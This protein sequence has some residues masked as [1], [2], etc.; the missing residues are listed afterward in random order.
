MNTKRHLIRK[1]KISQKIM[2]EKVGNLLRCGDNGKKNAGCTSVNAVPVIEAKRRD[3]ETN[4]KHNMKT[5]DSAKLQRT[6]K[7]IHF[8]GLREMPSTQTNA[9]EVPNLSCLRIRNK[10]KRPFSDYFFPI[11]WFFFCTNLIPSNTFAAHFNCEIVHFISIFILFLV[12]F[13]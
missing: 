7:S 6:S 5:A 1:K 10:F 9:K 3:K 8:V 4:L 11:S 2:A 13:H 12:Y